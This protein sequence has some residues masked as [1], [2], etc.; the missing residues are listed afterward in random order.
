MNDYC[1]NY[2]DYCYY[3]YNN[4]YCNSGYYMNYYIGYFDL[5]DYYCHLC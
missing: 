5:L 1:Y 3:Y 4:G 2:D